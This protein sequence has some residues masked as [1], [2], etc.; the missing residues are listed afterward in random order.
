[1][2]ADHQALEMLDAFASVGAQ[3]F[4]LTFTDNAGDKVGFRGNRCLEQLRATLPEI[5]TAAAEQQHNIIVRPR[6]TGLIQLDDLGEA[7]AE[8]MR[9]V[10]FLVLRSRVDGQRGTA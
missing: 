7:V 1:M 5:L 9:S 6:S 4:D 2:S 8:K 3:R 10:S